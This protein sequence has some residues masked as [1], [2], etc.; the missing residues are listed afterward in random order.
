MNQVSGRKKTG[1]IIMYS[2]L[3]LAILTFFA[4]R[5]EKQ[6]KAY[7]RELE[8]SC[9]QSPSS[10]TA[11]DSI[12]L[13][14]NYVFN[15]QPFQATIIDIGEPGHLESEMMDSVLEKIK[16]KFKNALK[17]VHYCAGDQGKMQGHFAVKQVPALIVLDRHAAQCYR[18]SGYIAYD[19]LRKEVERVIN[20]K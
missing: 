9:V 6:K 1:M 15:H 13:V 2:L 16:L 5:F 10:L 4:F 18:R 17:I 14:F 7:L 19:D 12:D 20:Q 11:A 3:I 8:R